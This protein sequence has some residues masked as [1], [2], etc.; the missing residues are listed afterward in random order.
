[1]NEIFMWLGLFAAGLI[2]CSKIPG[3]E[4]LVK[5]VIGLV[6]SAIQFIAENG[7]NW[8]IWLFKILWGSHIEFIRHF[9]VPIEVLDPSAAVRVDD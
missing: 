5:P 7:G 6:F 9:I 2:V 3:I 1:M 4:H 8:C